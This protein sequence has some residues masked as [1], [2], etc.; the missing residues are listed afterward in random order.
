MPW[1][2][3][4][5]PV[6]LF[7]TLIVTLS[8]HPALNAA[9]EPGTKNAAGAEVKTRDRQVAPP[10]GKLTL[11]QIAKE[12]ESDEE[13]EGKESKPKPAE[14]STKKSLKRPLKKTPRPGFTDADDSEAP[15]PK[16]AAAKARHRKTAQPTADVLE[17]PAAAAKAKGAEKMSQITL[18]NDFIEK[19]K[20]R[21]TIRTPFRVVKTS[22]IH[23]VEDDGEQHIAGLAE[24][25]GL[26]VVAELMQAKVE[27][28]AIKTIAEARDSEELI[29][30]VGAWRLWCEHPGKPQIQG[31]VIA[32]YKTSN[33][34]H[35]FEIHP[36]SQVG[37]LDVRRTFR[38]TD[39][40]EPYDAARAFKYYDSL[41]CRLE[42]DPDAQT[43]SIF[44]VKSKF[45]FAEFILRIEDDEQFITL[46]GRI[47][48]CSVLDLEGHDV[49][50]DRRM[51]FI[52]GTPPEKAIRT[53]GRG[54][55]LHVVGIPRVDL[56]I[57]SWRVRNA[58]SRPE[59][60]EWGLP[61]EMIVVGVYDD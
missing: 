18:R 27:D 17:A 8:N 44:T 61:Y 19:Y 42:P 20:N 21:V 34:D 43:T 40:Y 15:A 13:N 39:G 45:N 2:V 53:L 14:S 38:P 16:A 25:I 50:H 30:V 6:A 22:P 60:L 56:A 49:T 51:V 28:Q 31:D 1:V 46:D 5:V 35:V 59:A 54:S 24:E 55:E 26:P 11:E 33:P 4:L 23:K 32:E 10:G 9:Q 37:S 36:L 47:V 48:R 12:T 41:P 57:I 52:K 29:D 3:R 58:E 7:A